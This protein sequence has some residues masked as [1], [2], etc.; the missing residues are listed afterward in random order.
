MKPAR[1]LPLLIPDDEWA[2]LVIGAPVDGPFTI[3]AAQV[4]VPGLVRGEVYVAGC[5]GQVYVPGAMV[6]AVANGSYGGD[7][8]DPEAVEG[9]VTIQAL[10][11]AG[12][13]VVLPEGRWSVDP[14]T[15]PAT[16]TSVTG[17]APN[18]ADIAA[19]NPSSTVLKLNDNA[20]DFA[21][22]FRILHTAAGNRTVAISRLMFNM[23]RYNQGP[24]ANYECEHQAA[25]YISGNGSTGFLTVTINNVEVYDSAGDATYVHHRSV[26][27]FTNYNT[28]DIFRSG[29][30]ITGNLSTTTV[31]GCDL[32]NSRFDIEPNS[33]SH[34]LTVTV[35]DMTCANFEIGLNSGC[36]FT[37]NNITADGYL[38]LLCAPGC[39]FTCTNS[40]FTGRFSFRLP[41]ATFTNC[42]FRS[43]A[44]DAANIIYM[45]WAYNSLTTGMTCTLTNCQILGP[46]LVGIHAGRDELADGNVLNL[47]N[48]QINSTTSA[49]TKDGGDRGTWNWTNVTDDG[50]AITP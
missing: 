30:V 18:A 43:P 1:L 39:S 3:A 17:A 5:T 7:E 26:V 10:L 15:F 4:Y 29:I 6:G 28:E 13:A 14:L 22:I 40:D 49:V 34:T 21:R 11:N 27:A 35:D 31:S 42:V 2:A 16:V 36:T 8:A 32:V 20:G 50:V 38:Y 12:G 37:G 45:A 44:T 48:V 9:T 19:G 46:A 25:M 23:N 47:T 33:Q 41:H 24:Y